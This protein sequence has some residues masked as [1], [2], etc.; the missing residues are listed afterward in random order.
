MGWRYRE[1]DQG[2]L[3]KMNVVGEIHMEAYY[4]LNHLN[5]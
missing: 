1:G 3:T 2:L 5:I 4:F